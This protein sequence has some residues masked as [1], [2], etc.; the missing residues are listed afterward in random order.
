MV[1]TYFNNLCLNL[2]GVKQRG[3]LNFQYKTKQKKTEQLS[4]IH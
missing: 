4:I 3:S 2:K 1:I